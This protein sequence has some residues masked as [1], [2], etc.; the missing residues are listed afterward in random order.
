LNNL[1]QLQQNASR[2]AVPLIDFLYQIWYDLN[3]LSID[4]PRAIPVA[5]LTSDQTAR[6][7]DV[8]N[9]L[10]SL[11]IENLSPSDS[12]KMGLQ[13][14]IEGKKTPEDLLTDVKAKYVALGR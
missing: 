2:T 11:R 8:A 13:E 3:S 14:Y 12:L 7:K 9:T 1:L 4:V 5:K 10:A 6:E